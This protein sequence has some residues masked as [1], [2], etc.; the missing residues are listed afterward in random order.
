MPNRTANNLA[1]S[2]QRLGRLAMYV[3]L[4]YSFKGAPLSGVTVNG[5]AALCV[6]GSRVAGLEHSP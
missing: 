1:E 2:P 6:D 3:T 5:D 4:G